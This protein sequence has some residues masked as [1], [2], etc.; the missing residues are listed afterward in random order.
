[1][2]VEKKKCPEIKISNQLIYQYKII[3]LINKR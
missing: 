3:R 2:L 1:M